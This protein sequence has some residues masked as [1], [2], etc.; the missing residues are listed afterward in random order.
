MYL[1]QKFEQ[2][3]QRKEAFLDS[4]IDSGSNQELFA[5]CYIHGHLSVVASQVFTEDDENLSESEVSAAYAK[6]TIELTS[7]I[8]KA[9]NEKELEGQDAMDVL[10]M[11]DRLN[12][13]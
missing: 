6:F 4:F 10:Q 12:A 9:I 7:N 11:L 13:S 2:F 3:V 8:R 5:A 1:S